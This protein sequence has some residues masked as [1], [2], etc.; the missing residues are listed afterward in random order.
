MAISKQV[1]E[2]IELLIFDLDGTLVDSELDLALSVNFVL[3]EMGQKPLSVERIASYVGRGVRVLVSRALGPDATEDDVERGN[4]LFLDHYCRHMLDHTVP[5]PGVREALEGLRGRKMAVL[6]N[7]PVKF[8]RL[9]L[10]GL[11]L[12][13]HFSYIYG[14][15]SFENKKPDPVGVFQLMG[16]FDT[17]A[18]ET[19]MIGDSVS[20][21]LAGRNAGVW[22]CGVS[23]GFGSPTL[24]E[25][26][27]D[28]IIGDLR[29]LPRL[30]DGKP[31]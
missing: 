17:A 18:G 31:E 1:L 30:L 19:L 4:N 23:Y 15:N 10:A 2:G 21:V 26:P 16:D 11:G 5:Y 12:T 24:K 6:T 13:E 7:K 22:T 3:Q 28:L 27:P 8:S 9:M 14:G 29:E 20:D 25:T